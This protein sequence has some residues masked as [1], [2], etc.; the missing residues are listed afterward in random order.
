MASSNDHYPFD[1]PPPDVSGETYTFRAPARDEGLESFDAGLSVTRLVVGAALWGMDALMDSLLTWDAVSRNASGRIP[2]DSNMSQESFSRQENEPAD[3]IVPQLHFQYSERFIRRR[4]AVV[5]LVFSARH[6]LL[7]GVK[8]LDRLQQRIGWR[9]AEA[10]RP[11]NRLPLMRPFQQRFDDLLQRGEREVDLL[12]RLGERESEI[13]RALAQTALHEQVE[14]S[15]EYLAEHPEVKELVQLQSTGLADEA[16][17]EIRERSVSADNFVE[18]LVRYM[19]RLLPRQEIPPPPQEVRE[20]AEKLHPERY[21]KQT[22][23]P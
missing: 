12:M 9:I 7:R 22:K 21:Q 3:P 6:A 17:E 11:V 20:R 18:G 1:T 13:S 14:E 19:L 2:P 4:H 5:G 8:R 10:A 16:V 15:I 23:K